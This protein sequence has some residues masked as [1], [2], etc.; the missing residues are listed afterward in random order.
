MVY[1]HA[2]AINTTAE[3]LRPAKIFFKKKENRF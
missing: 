1:K 2:K 3:R